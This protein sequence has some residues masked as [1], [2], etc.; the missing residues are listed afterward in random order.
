MLASYEDTESDFTFCPQQIMCFFVFHN[1]RWRN[2][3]FRLGGGIGMCWLTI[4]ATRPVP[5][6]DDAT[7][8]RTRSL[9]VRSPYNKR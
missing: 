4:L 5:V 1:Q 3:D 6:A 7:R 9:P 8:T 2:H